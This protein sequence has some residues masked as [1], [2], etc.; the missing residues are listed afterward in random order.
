MEIKS[1]IT[2][3]MFTNLAGCIAIVEACTQTIKILCADSI[4]PYTLLIAFIFSLFVSVIRLFFTEDFS[5]ENII[6]VLIN[7]VVIFLGSV[8]VYQVGIKQI[9]RLLT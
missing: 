8:G 9:E 6:L 5:K 3:D 7:V 2:K 4:K 1:F